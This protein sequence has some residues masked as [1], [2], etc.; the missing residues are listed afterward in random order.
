MNISAEDHRVSKRELVG[1]FLPAYAAPLPNWYM[2]CEA[3]RQ[4]ACVSLSETHAWIYW[5]CSSP[6]I[7]APTSDRGLNGR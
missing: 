7:G 3:Q 1:R 4:K 2:R 6:K 5:W